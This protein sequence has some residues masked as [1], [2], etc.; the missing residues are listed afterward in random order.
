M[1]FWTEHP[2][3]YT[4]LKQDSRRL[5]L[6]P[7]IRDTL[8]KLG[9]KR[10]FDYGC[11][12]GS[13]FDD[14]KIDL[15]EVCLFDTSEFMLDKAKEKYGER[16]KFSIV[17]DVESV[18]TNHFDG[19]VLSLVLM[20]IP[21]IR[22]QQYIFQQ[23][24]RIKTTSGTCIVAVTHPCFHNYE[25]STFK[26]E[27]VNGRSFEYL[28]QG[29]PYSV[30]L[31]DKSKNVI[32]DFKDYHWPLATM[33]NLIVSAGISIRKAVELNDKEIIEGNGFNPNFPPY[34]VFHCE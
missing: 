9:C 26:T 27:F 21:S 1:T 14:W 3:L 25:F 5:V 20:T 22:E 17:K 33:I 2:L 15:E 13:L 12:D 4:L 16:K 28:N 29:Q 8:E 32:V 30:E 7:Y 31:T 23:I 34:L 18:P 10:I 6:H 11:G 19:V 24:K